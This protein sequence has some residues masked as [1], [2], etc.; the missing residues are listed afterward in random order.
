MSSNIKTALSGSDFQFVEGVQEIADS[1]DAFII[2]LWGVVHDGIALHDGVMHCLDALL[3]RDK[4]VLFLSNTPQ[5]AGNIE[6]KLRQ[7]GVD[8]NRC[9]GVET[10][11]EAA[12]KTLT[13]APESLGL[14][15]S[16]AYFP[17]GDNELDYPLMEALPFKKT[18]NLEDADFIL[19]LRSDAS[20]ESMKRYTPVFEAAI[21]N[22]I[23]LICLN[24][25]KSVM[26]QGS[27]V[28]C[29]G[30]L[31]E[32]YEDLGG[33]VTY[34]GKPHKPVY[35]TCF[36]ALGLDPSRILAVGDSL[37][38]DI[39]GANRMGIDSLLVMTGIHGS[40][41]LRKDQLSHADNRNS[42]EALMVRAKSKPTFVGQGFF[43]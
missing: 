40:A 32:L 35:D 24:P 38:T 10:A 16:G 29:A 41:I 13:Q 30:A 3:D 43:W 21:E 23:S 37:A 17:I 33:D 34:F 27:H 7:L 36:Q 14:R 26:L 4:K 39:A 28:L 22:G 9:V 19:L 31:A 1:Y 6:G 12:F 5:R 2:D 15:K 25:D 11:G 20:Y 42:L 18:S 8:L